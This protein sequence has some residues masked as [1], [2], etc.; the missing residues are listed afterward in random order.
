MYRM[1]AWN[2]E[3]KTPWNVLPNTEIALA[4]A[5]RK[6]FSFSKLMLQIVKIFRPSICRP[7]RQLRAIRYDMQ[8]ENILFSPPLFQSV[9]SSTH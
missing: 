7:S 2:F 8:L 1:T 6:N 4:E 5:A 3:G 9:L